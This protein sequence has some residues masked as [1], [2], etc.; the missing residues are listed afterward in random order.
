MTRI[1]R[2]IANSVKYRVL[3]ARQAMERLWFLTPEGSRHRRRLAELRSAY[4]GRRC[5]VICNGPSL[6][7]TDIRLIR[8]EVT[9]G[10]NAIFLLFDETGFR[11]TFLTVEDQLVAEDRAGEL[12]E[13]RGVRKVFP[14]DLAH[15]L[16]A[17]DDTTYVH[18]VRHY[19][20]P[21]FSPAFESRAY[22]GGTVTFFNLQLAYHL[23]CDP[24][25]LIGCDH[26]YVVPPNLQ[27]SV[28]TS[29][30]D[31]VNHFHPGYFGK[32]YRWHDPQVDRM[33]AAYRAA[34]DF[35]DAHAVRVFN[36]TDGGK[37]EVFP[38]VRYGDVVGGR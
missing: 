18:F 15:A 34:K 16:R 28:I 31:D 37:L 6:K 27:S 10:S 2:R 13:L 3:L 11:P 26:N 24:I 9:I 23:G 8:D 29:G 5:F 1:T 38:R 19:P 12:N 4:L 7:R 21:R 20:F 33:E 35:L 14:R 22:W 36:A 17:D 25:Y 32:G 30:E